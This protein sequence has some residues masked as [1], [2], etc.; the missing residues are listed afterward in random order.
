MSYS[1]SS[2]SL[3][4]VSHCCIQSYIVRIRIQAQNTQAFQCAA[5]LFT[6]II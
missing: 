2:E 5:A 3:G 1:K 6:F 4:Y